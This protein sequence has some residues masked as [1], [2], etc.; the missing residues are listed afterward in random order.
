MAHSY[1]E[2]QWT[3]EVL[4]VN[5]DENFPFLIEQTVQRV[6]AYEIT[7]DSR[8]SVTETTQSETEE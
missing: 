5:E 3:K 4:N 7:S 8:K 6:S 2:L 1:S